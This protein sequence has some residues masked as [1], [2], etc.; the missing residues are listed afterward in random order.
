VR[1][2]TVLR[3]AQDGQAFANLARAFHL[4][5]EKV[6]TAV[7]TMI[8]ELIHHIERSTLSRRSL[9]ALVELLGQSAYEEVLASPMRLAA[10]S[11]QVIGN[12]ALNVIAGRDGSKETARLSAAAAGI[13]EMIAEY[14]LP[15][16]AAMLVGALA[17][18][19]RPGLEA[20]MGGDPDGAGA[21]PLSPA[22]EA[23]PAPLQLPRVAGGAG[24][25]GS[26]GGS[27][28]GAS[29]ASAA[30]HYVELA[31]D[32]R[33]EGR[34]PGAPDPAKAV[35]RTLDSVLGFPADTRGLIGRIE[36]W[37]RAAFKAILARLRR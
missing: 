27:G 14:L 2:E 10:T 23:N 34:A 20:L 37:G 29:P 12:N 24:F 6:D 3:E 19:S 36:S 11:T 35:R 5:P 15:V 32:I 1:I 9:S 26:T 33:R 28:G 25:S 22:S 8:G 17:K 13:S 18:L 7:G 31:E 30:I 21:R 16:I 4:P